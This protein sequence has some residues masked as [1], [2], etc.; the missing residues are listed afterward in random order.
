MNEIVYL[1]GHYVPKSQAVI[2]IEDRGFQF[3]DGVYDLAKFCGRRPLRFA[4]HIGRLI[5]SCARVGICGAPS[6]GDWRR[7]AERLVGE[8]ALSDDTSV[9]HILYMQVTRGVAPRNYRLPESIPPTCLAYFLPAPVYTAE[10]RENGVQLISYPDE[11]WEHCH[12]KTIML[13]P[14]VLAKHAAF[15]AGAFDALLVNRNGIVTEGTSSNAFCVR[16]DVVHTHP[17]SGTILPGVTRIL[18]GEAA[19]RAG[20]QVREVAMTLE[21]F[22]AADELFLSSTS[23]H[24]MPATVVDGTPVADGRVGP[25]TR[26]LAGVLDDMVRKEIEN[27]PP[28]GA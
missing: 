13:L 5:E 15:E 28:F 1:N 9:T 2:P 22:K 20:V 26:R 23:M 16:G 7:I 17:T 8:C 25:V 18:V 10:Q 4:E 11:R 19:A 24:I 21:E 12:V 6:A 27:C 3:A 14:T